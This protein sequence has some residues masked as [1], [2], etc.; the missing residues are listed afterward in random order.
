[1]DGSAS[2]HPGVRFPPPALFALGFGAGWLLHGTN[3][4]PLL[5]GAERP[6][7]ATVVGGSSILLGAMLIVWA[8]V[9]F[10]RARTGIIPNRPAT[11]LV[12]DGPYRFTRNPMYL[13]FIVIYLGGSLLINSAWTLLILPLVLFILYTAVIHREERYL[14]ARFGPD[15]DE[16]RMRIRRWV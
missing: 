15:Y 5:G 9:S 7:V 11:M 4:I 2:A 14:A 1:M 8:I 10:R 13:A 16:Y 6:V 12:L 3:P